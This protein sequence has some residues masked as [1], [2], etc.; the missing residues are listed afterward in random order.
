MITA[1][2]FRQKSQARFLDYISRRRGPLK[3][4]LQ[5]GYRQIFIIPS[6]FGAGFAVLL[7]VMTVAGLNY[8]NNLALI[9]SYL[10]LAIFLSVS[11][12]GYRNLRGLNI[13]PA[14]SKPVF[15]GNF[16]EFNI[17][18]SSH[19]GQRFALECWQE[20]C[21]DQLTAKPGR[22]ASLLIRKKTEKRG[23]LSLGPWKLQS[24]WPFGFYRV[25]SW[26]VPDDTCLVYPAPVENPPPLPWSGSSVG[27]SSLAQAGDDELHGLRDYQA[28][29]PLNRIAWRSSARADRLITRESEQQQSGEIILDWDYLPVAGTELRL[30]ILCAWVLEAEKQKLNWSMRLPGESLTKGSGRGHQQRALSLLALYDE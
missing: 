27:L 15:A 18:V 6:R 21:C 13:S 30:S 10:L 22:P 1:K 12:L 28:G 20:E 3:P 14:I 11:N 26:I 25:W 19:Q 29:D 16:A 4:P 2:Q 23:R 7:L 17:P 24:A 8:N 5:L 9:L